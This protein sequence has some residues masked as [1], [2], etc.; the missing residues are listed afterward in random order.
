MNAHEGNPCSIL[1]GSTHPS[2]LL[3]IFMVF[4]LSVIMVFTSLSIVHH[5]CGCPSSP[6]HALLLSVSIVIALLC[7]NCCV[8][9]SSLCCIIIAKCG[10]GEA[11][12]W[13]WLAGVIMA[14]GGVVAIK[15]KKEGDWR[16]LQCDLL[17]CTTVDSND[18]MHC[19]C[20]DVIAH[21]EGTIGMPNCI[22]HVQLTWQVL[23]LPGMAGDMVLACYCH[24]GWH[25]RGLSWRTWHAMAM[26]VLLSLG[27][28][29]WWSMCRPKC[30]L[31]HSGHS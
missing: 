12:M 21:L 2:L 14:T 31:T 6:P 9:S 30:H 4:L 18:E 13:Q 3:S 8:L 1:E 15:K 24:H 28:V 5:C 11:M 17:T 20:L 26:L 10:R 29:R 19:C 22:L 16:G 25:G 23:I 7:S 27:H